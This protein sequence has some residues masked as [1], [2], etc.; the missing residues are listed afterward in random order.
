MAAEA[1][2]SPFDLHPGGRHFVFANCYV[3][4]QSVTPQNSL[5]Y[6]TSTNGIGEAF[7][8]RGPDCAIYNCTV[9]GAFQGIAVYNGSERARISGCRLI[10]CNTGIY[11][12][13]SNDI[14]VENTE[15]VN[16]INYGLRMASN[17]G[18]WGVNKFYASGVR[19][20]GNPSVAAFA[21]DSWNN[22]FYIDPSCVAPDATTKMTGRLA[23]TIASAAT[24]SLPALGDTFQVTGTTNIGAMTANLMYHGRRVVLR[25]A[26]ALTVSSGTGLSLTTPMSTA[27]GSVLTQYCDGSSWYEVSRAGASSLPNSVYTAPSGALA[28]TIPR[29]TFNVANI[30]FLTSGT[31]LL[32]AISLV[33]GQ[34]ISSITIFSR[35]TAGSGMTNQWFGL[36]SAARVCLAVTNDDTS[37][38][39]IQN[40]AKTLN[41][42]SSYTVPSTGLYYIGVMVAG[43]TVPT[44][45][46]LSQATALLS[47]PAPIVVGNSSTGLTSPFTVGNTAGALSASS[48]GYLYAYV[49]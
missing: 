10:A 39:W 8:L 47:T 43:T 6:G 24:L 9:V 14:R 19:V 40:T 37:N 4:N 25:I 17:S 2:N 31:L 16:P 29:M 15:I 27:A 28:E 11:L 48:L 34:L 23:T 42:T 33:Q 12:Q 7:K 18:G 49:S 5:R 41:L 30:S 3:H 13:N 35:S 46:G 45:V 22:G 20:T 21:F 38:A 36:F 1:T 26:D 44:L 32:Q